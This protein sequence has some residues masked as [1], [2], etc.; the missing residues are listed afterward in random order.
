[1]DYAS[2]HRQ[3]TIHL[4]I[5]PDDNQYPSNVL[6]IPPDGGTGAMAPLSGAAKSKFEVSTVVTT[7]AGDVPA[8]ENPTP[9]GDRSSG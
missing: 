9:T 6:V 3:R 4:I 8:S 2:F 1:V 7:L 5:L